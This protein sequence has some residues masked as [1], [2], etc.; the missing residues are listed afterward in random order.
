MKQPT[1]ERIATHVIL[2]IACSIALFPVLW[3]VSTSFKNQFDV[4]STEIELIPREP[5]L[6]NY[7]NLFDPTTATGG[8]FWNWFGN[9]LLISVLTTVLSVFLASTAAYALSRYRFFGKRGATSFFLTSQMFPA[10][11]LLVPL[12][13]LLAIRLGLL[14]TPWALVLA[15]ATTAIPFCVLML[16]SYF[17]TLP[18][19]L[20]EAAK[21][22][23]PRAARR[24]LADRHPALDARYRGHRLLRLHHRVERVPVR[25]GLPHQAGGVHP[26]DRRSPLHQPVHPELGRD[27]GALR[28]RHH[29]G[30]DL[31]LP[32]PALPDQRPVDRRHQ[33]LTSAP[34]S[35]LGSRSRRTNACRG[36][37]DRLGPTIGAV[38]WLAELF[39]TNRIIVL[40][41]YGQVFFVMGLAVA[42]QSRQ[43]SE[44]PLARPLGWLA[45]SGS[46]TGSWPGATCS[47]RSRRGSCRCRSSSCS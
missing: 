10:V 18:I 16:K 44:L 7:Q 41:V 21:I 8:F 47:F 11:I 27:D 43:R 40:S 2:I 6:E 35:V 25:P 42:L 38:N 1:W 46:S 26:P 13:Q 15:Y 45:A 19:E 23:G 14:N 30:G 31:L 4:L 28:G 32:C 37:P 17:D 9:S 33:G 39:E 22:D 24:L 36:P 3:I 20:E 34:G 12:F 29:P 5:T